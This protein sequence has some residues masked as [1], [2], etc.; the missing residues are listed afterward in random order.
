MSNVLRLDRTVHDIREEARAFNLGLRVPVIWKP[1]A[2]LGRASR[3]MLD[4][5]E[6]NAA[7]HVLLLEDLND[8]IKRRGGQFLCGAR[9]TNQRLHEI[10]NLTGPVTERSFHIKVSCRKC[11]QLAQRW[12]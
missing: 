10:W 3:R 12:Q 2:K 4:G 6:W 11:L 1:A 7:F 8:G 9:I 5:L